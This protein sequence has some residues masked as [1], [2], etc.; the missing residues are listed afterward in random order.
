MARVLAY[1]PTLQTWEN[2]AIQKALEARRTAS[3]K[4]AAAKVN[5]T[6]TRKS[7]KS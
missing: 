5:T 7:S 1:S 3:D 6:S 4:L 2:E